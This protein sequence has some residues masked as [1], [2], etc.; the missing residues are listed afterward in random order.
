MF[1]NMSNDWMYGMGS[2]TWNRKEERLTP[3]V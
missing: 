2:M 1:G 3:I